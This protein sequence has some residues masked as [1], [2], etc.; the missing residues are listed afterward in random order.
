MAAA[1]PKRAGMWDSPAP[2]LVLRS[3]DM[4]IVL[5]L[6]LWLHL[7]SLGLGGA[8]TFG[9]PV[10]LMVAEGAP[11]E[12]R[13]HFGAL[14]MRLSFLGRVAIGLLIVS[15]VIMVWGSYGLAGL[16]GWFWVKMALVVALVG[17]VRFNLRNGARAR[18]GD[19]AAAARMPVLGLAGIALFAAIVLAAV[20]TFL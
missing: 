11:A 3:D 5:T 8:A 6:S 1:L 14:A 10:L 17:L 9:I 19:Q 15:G 12:V 16:S 20:L 13:P 18:A 4:Q 7:V 2:G